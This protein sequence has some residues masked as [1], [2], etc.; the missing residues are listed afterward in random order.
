MTQTQNPKF[1]IIFLAILFLGFFG[2]TQTTNAER[3]F[4]QNSTWYEK[5]P[6]NPVLFTNSSNYIQDILINSGYFAA[7]Y[8]E[9][10]V[11][12]H[13][14]PPGTSNVTVTMRSPTGICGSNAIANHWNDVPIPA[15][16]L[17]AANTANCLGEYRDGHMVIYSDLYVWEFFNAEYCDSVWYTSCVRRYARSGDGLNAPYDNLG[18]CR[19]CPGASLT[20]GIV[21]KSEI[22]AGVINHALSFC[23]W[24]EG[25]NGS[26]NYTSE[27]PCTATRGEVS[28]RTYAMHMGMRIQLDPSWNC[29]SLGEGTFDAIICKALQDYGAIFVDNC[30]VGYNSIYIENLYN[31]EQGLGDW[32]GTWENLSSIPINQMRVVE[33]VCSDC[34]ICP[35]NCIVANDI[36]PPASPTGLVVQ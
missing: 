2:F 1:K 17:P 16:A 23:Y 34:N 19:A 10:S 27:Y 12:I 26:G 8:G 3:F 31:G 5:I 15:G 11:P 21:W 32:T 7:A 25:N 30:G 4:Q 33:P 18:W 13:Y 22:D 24:A 28:S 9:W 35:D 36:T 29:N 20:H 6:S 14:S